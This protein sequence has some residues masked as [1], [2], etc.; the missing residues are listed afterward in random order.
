MGTA[1]KRYVPVTAMLLLHMLFYSGMASF[2]LRRD[3]VNRLGTVMLPFF[4]SLAIAAVLL[5]VALRWFR[6][7]EAGVPSR[8]GRWRMV[9]TLTALLAFPLCMTAGFD[10]WLQ[11][12]PLRY[13]SNMAMALYMPIVYTLFYSR[14]TPR[15]H[16]LW[17]GIGV[18][19]GFVLWRVLVVFAAPLNGESVSGL[20]AVYVTQII[21]SIILAIVLIL[22]ILTR[23]SQG[24][25]SN[26]DA[27]GET[28]SV[29]NRSYTIIL[30]FAASGLIYV[31]NSFIDI[32]MFPILLDRT[33]PPFEPLQ[34]I[35]AL[36]CPFVGW[37]FD[38]NPAD[39]FRRIA[40]ACA[41]VFILAPSLAM[42]GDT[43]G[44]YRLVHAATA[45]GQFAVL[46]LF[47]TVL[48]GLTP[49][50]DGIGKYA[51]L[52]YAWRGLSVF[53]FLLVRVTMKLPIG[54]ATLIATVMAMAY[55]LVIRR[56]NI[57]EPS[58]MA[59]TITTADSSFPIPKRIA[60]PQ[61]EAI[62]PPA[63]PTILF[64]RHNLT[65]RECEVAALWLQGTS[66]RD[67]A[68]QLGISESTVKTHITKILGKLGVPN[69]TAFYVKLLD[70]KI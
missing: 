23:R 11:D 67:M 16:G 62:S 40:F 22:G 24:T 57:G 19:A 68:L 44:L 47:S 17:F 2:T 14:A 59:E 21:L 37:L 27:P 60:S 13:V 64:H 50:D 49:P 41:C 39:N 58:E 51:G 46:V 48:A 3:Q 63:D 52:L 36:S 7:A 66:T 31:M 70:E 25:V 35:A 26:R 8:A 54:A 10:R 69:R 4:V 28:W 12:I 55:Y 43:P 15:H 38:R 18:A 42:L 61:P 20:Y 6:E 5:P 53:G 30:I 65:P 45:A 32:R 33:A 1:L 56:I 29:P 9:P 34:L